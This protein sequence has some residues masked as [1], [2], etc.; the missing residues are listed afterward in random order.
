MKYKIIPILFLMTQ[1]LSMAYSQSIYNGASLS[2]NGTCTLFISGNFSNGSGATYLNNGFVEIKGDIGNDQSSMNPG[3]G[4][5]SLSGNNAQNISGS[6]PFEVNNI[7]F[8]NSS[9]G[10]SNI[11]LI[12]NVAVSGV[13]TFSDGIT[14]TG[15]NKIIFRSGSSYSGES[16]GSHINGWVE[17]IGNSAFAFPIGDAT[18]LRTSSISA[19]SVSTDAFS[20]KYFKSDPNGVHIASAIDASLNHISR[21][22]YWSINRT[23]GSSTPVVTLSF[24]NGYS[25]GISQLSDLRVSSWNGS[26]WANNGNQSTTGDISFGTITASSSPSI[27][28][29]FTLSSVTAENIMPIELVSFKAFY[30]NTSNSVELSWTT[31]SETNS[32]Y[33]QTERSTDGINWDIVSTVN[34]SGFSTTA[35]NYISKD[36]NPLKGT[37]YYRLK[38]VD[39][40]GVFFYSPLQEVNINQIISDLTLR[41]NPFRDQLVLNFYGEDDSAANIVIR[42]IFG[43]EV[44]NMNTDSKIG[45]N[46]F[47]IETSLI[48]V[49]I[50]TLEIFRKNASVLEKAKIIK[51]K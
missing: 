43:Q 1:M 45:D 49:G 39:F 17:K 20:A 23:A 24:E 11:I 5:T 46:T 21:C 30:N 15:T 9:A 14:E 42:N 2:V 41:P 7:L 12:N 38:E 51:I 31:A 27:W 44:L 37:S 33:F 48:P 6:Q 8:S 16:D 4:N 36:C 10:S 25:C 28:G 18:K 32:N 47:T 19:P 22:E 13:A 40:D 26:L 50:Y 3:N 35:M 29:E 34:A